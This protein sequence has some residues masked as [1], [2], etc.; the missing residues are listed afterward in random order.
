MMGW[1]RGEEGMWVRGVMKWVR[2]GS[3]DDTTVGQ[4]CLLSEH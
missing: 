2:K 4:A 3:V 1:E